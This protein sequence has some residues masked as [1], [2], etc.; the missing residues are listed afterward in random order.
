MIFFYISHTGYA[1]AFPWG[2]RWAGE[3]G[4]D[5]G[6]PGG[7]HGVGNRRNHPQRR[8]LPLS[9]ESGIKSNHFFAGSAGEKIPLTS[10]VCGP[11]GAVRV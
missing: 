6:E 7:F 11:N 1:K 5:E 4:S 9:A 10:Q 8:R 3:A 2:G